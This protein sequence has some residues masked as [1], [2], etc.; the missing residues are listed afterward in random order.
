MNIRNKGRFLEIER[1]GQWTPLAVFDDDVI[2]YEVLPDT[3]VI[4]ATDI[5]RDSTNRNIF[6][7]DTSGNVK[8]QIQEAQGRPNPYSGFEVKKGKVIASSVQGAEYYV[9]PQTGKITLKDFNRF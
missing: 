7:I 3:T 1:A 6:L 9:D 4:V 5:T 8:W 2:Q